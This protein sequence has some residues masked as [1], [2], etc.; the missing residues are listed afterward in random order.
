M[1]PMMD[2]ATYSDAELQTA[3][4]SGDRLAEEVLV[5]RY[6][7]LVRSCARPLFLAGGDSEDLIQEGM[8]GI[9]SA[10]RQF[11][12]KAGASFR[13]FAEHCVRTRLLSAVKS[14][15]RLK[16]LPLN[17]GL[18]LEQLSEDSDAHMSAMSEILHQNPE[19]L[20]L[21][22]ERTEELYAELSQCLSKLEKQVLDLYLKGL[23]Y[24]E[25]AQVL[26]RDEKA[27]DN[28]VQR[29]RRKLARNPNF[30]DNSE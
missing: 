6:M 12:P 3:A 27:I 2:Y 10:I 26:K 16:H 28:A 18:S 23:S 21:A 29:I 17:D 11:D 4:S 24:R 30:S 7:R 22:R 15:S 5:E 8:F 19:D 20:I 25:I 13:T 9:L 1:W 14:A